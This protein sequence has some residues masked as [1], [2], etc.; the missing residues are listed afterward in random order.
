MPIELPILEEIHTSD[1]QGCARRVQH[2]ILGQC[3]PG[4]PT[5]MFR[6]LLAGAS[7]EHVHNEHRR[8]P[9]LAP[10]AVALGL[11]DTKAKMVSE[12][13]SLTDGAVRNLDQTVAECIKMCGY[14]IERFM[15]LF[16]QCE[17]IACELPIRWE[18]EHP[19]LEQSCHFASHLDLCFRDPENVWGHGA[20]RLHVWDWKWHKQSPSYAYLIRNMQMAIYYAAMGGGG[21]IL[22][23]KKHDIWQ[24][25]KEYPVVSWVHLPALMP[26]MRKT[27]G[28]S[29]DGEE[30][31]F[32]KGDER[33]LDRI[34]RN[35]GHNPDM[36]PYI[37][38][39]FAQHVLSM[40]MGIFLPSPDPVGCSLCPSEQ[41]CQRYDYSLQLDG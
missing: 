19:L 39:T 11:V 40:R 6:G 7:L 13:R 3:D 34:V 30:K 33:P 41:W 23:N 29:T 8:A 18:M 32:L 4:I 22:R 12:G 37:E 28:K 21:A 27:V 17:L 20:N 38:A 16:S 2:R 35:I 25:P 5:A 1:V 15:P 31:V 9:D 26:Y 36:V 14:Y 24:Q 10:E